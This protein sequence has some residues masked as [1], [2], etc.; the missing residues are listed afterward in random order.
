MKTGIGR[1]QSLNASIPGSKPDVTGILVVVEPI[2]PAMT[3]TSSGL[4]DVTCRRTAKVSALSSANTGAE[5]VNTPTTAIVAVQLLK[6]FVMATSLVECVVPLKRS[7]CARSLGRDVLSFARELWPMDA[8]SDQHLW[9]DS[10]VSDG[11][12]TRGCLDATL[13]FPWL[14][15]M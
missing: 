7:V 2:T 1:N 15:G 5:P 9:P 11:S 8:R 6:R 13:A 4:L 10:F 12:L 14:A 3:A